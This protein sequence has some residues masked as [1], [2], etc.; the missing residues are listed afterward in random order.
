[1]TTWFVIRSNIKCER[2]AEGNL[3]AAGFE[4]YAPRTRDER[5]VR[6]R[7]IFVTREDS[8]MPRYLFL[9]FETVRIATGD[10]KTPLRDVT[11]SQVPWGVIRECQGVESILGI[12]GC[13]LPLSRE[14]VAML[15][16][17]IT[18]EQNLEYDYTRAG[19]LHRKEIGRSKK[20]TARLVFKPGK[21]ITVREGPFTNM[22]GEIIDVTSRGTVEAL[23]SV[24]GRMSTA[25]FPVEWL[26]LDA[27]PIAA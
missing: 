20:E 10:E 3:R 27:G 1:M 12:G 5:F 13:P 6:R 9:G 2:K 25:E 16:A 7:R 11:A 23:I 4:V 26:E 17:I 19:K 24:F 15:G 21:R 22:A 18:A 14:G 8:L